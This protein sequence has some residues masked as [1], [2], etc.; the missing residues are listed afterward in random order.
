MSKK[1]FLPVQVTGCTSHGAVNE[2]SYGDII[3]DTEMCPLLDKVVWKTALDERHYGYLLNTVAFVPVEQRGN[4]FIPKISNLPIVDAQHIIDE[5]TA[6]NILDGQKLILSIS[7]TKKDLS[8]ILNNM[9][10]DKLLSG[11]E[12]DNCGI[13]ADKNLLEDIADNVV[14]NIDDVAGALS[15]SILQAGLE[16]TKQQPDMRTWN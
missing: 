8:M 16:A 11:I 15:G 4:E 9:Q 12:L 7:A 6:D 10:K 5:D 2:I 3:V 1:Y 13:I 14:A